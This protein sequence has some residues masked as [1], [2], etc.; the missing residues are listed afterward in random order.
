MVD[1]VSMIAGRLA[2]VSDRNQGKD[3]DESAENDCTAHPEELTIVA[4]WASGADCKGK[5]RKAI[6]KEENRP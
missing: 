3:N 5:E 1:T 6:S 4:V 2:I